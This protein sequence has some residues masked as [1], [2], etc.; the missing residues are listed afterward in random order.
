MK[1]ARLCCV[2][3][4][5]NDKV[6]F[7]ICLQYSFNSSESRTLVNLELKLNVYESLFYRFKGHDKCN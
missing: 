1:V 5:Q 3:N 6:N 7:N 4:R 2:V